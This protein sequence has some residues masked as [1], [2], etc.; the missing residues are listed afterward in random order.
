MDYNLPDAIEGTQFMLIN[1]QNKLYEM[2]DDLEK[3]EFIAL[4]I[5]HHDT[6]SYAGLTC[7]LQIST[8][9]CDYIIDVLKF[10]NN[11]YENFSINKN[12][13]TTGGLSILNK[14]LCNPN[15][16]KIIHGSKSDIE[17]MQKDLGLYVVNLF[18]T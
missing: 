2:I 13:D 1:D 9:N 16:L 8:K 7:L 18:D 15:K 4:D 11:R 14:V 10:I 6:Y 3:E 5:E 12:F 17:W